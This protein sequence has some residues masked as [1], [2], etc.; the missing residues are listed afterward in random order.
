MNGFCKA[1]YAG[2]Y[3]IG[4]TICYILLVPY[5]LIVTV[6]PSFG[7]FIVGRRQQIKHSFVVFL[8]TRPKSKDRK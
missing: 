1:N 5:H 3:T 7:C 6:L 4:T 8:M 2:T